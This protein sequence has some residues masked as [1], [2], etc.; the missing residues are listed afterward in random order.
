METDEELSETG[1]A[2]GGLVD[3]VAGG[4]IVNKSLLF[5]GSSAD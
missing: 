2:A 5:S 3:D 4:R 1:V